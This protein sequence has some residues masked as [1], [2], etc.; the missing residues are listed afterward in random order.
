MLNNHECMSSTENIH[1]EESLRCQSESLKGLACQT[2][3]ARSELARSSRET[4]NSQNAP[5]SRSYC[6]SCSIS[7]F[8]NPRSRISQSSIDRVD[9]HCHTQNTSVNDTWCASS[10]NSRSSDITRSRL[11][12]DQL[13]KATGVHKRQSRPS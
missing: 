12:G 7:R 1:V 11:G 6:L 13:R 5:Q 4:T 10:S 3:K 2:P 9:G 8:A